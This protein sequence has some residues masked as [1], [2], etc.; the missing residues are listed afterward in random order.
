MRTLE[1][2]CVHGN[3]FFEERIRQF[4]VELAQ[5]SN[6]W[7]VDQAVD[8][9]EELR[10]HLQYNGYFGLL[11]AFSSLERYLERLYKFTR[12]IATRP[13]L[14]DAMLERVGWPRLEDYKDFLVALGITL[15]KTWDQIVKLNRFRDAI[16]HQGGVVTSDN[17]SRLKHYGY[18]DKLKYHAYK[19]GDWLTVSI[20]DVR[21]SI[22]L[23]QDTADLLTTDYIKALRKK[24]LIRGK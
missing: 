22:K 3:K 11:M 8:M 19:E 10:T 15:P 12:H 20:N 14:R 1:E 23:V 13:A 17:E 18:K 16:A 24:R 2:Y 9:R 6:G 4:Q 5:N 7:D 21:K